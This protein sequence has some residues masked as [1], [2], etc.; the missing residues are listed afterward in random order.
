MVYWN[1]LLEWFIDMRLLEC[2]AM[3]QFFC[4]VYIYTSIFFHSRFDAMIPIVIDAFRN[5]S[6]LDY[7]VMMFSFLALLVSRDDTMQG[8]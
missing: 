8:T 3:A 5:L 4:V 7:D 6:L 1:G 2:V